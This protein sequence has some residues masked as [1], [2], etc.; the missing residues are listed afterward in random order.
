VLLYAVVKLEW[1]ARTQ[2]DSGQS[3]AGL[4]AA[5]AGLSGGEIVSKRGLRRRELETVCLLLKIC[6]GA[7]DPGRAGWARF[8]LLPGAEAGARTRTVM[9]SLSK[10]DAADAQLFR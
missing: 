3:V 6:A 10:L 8:A 5:R 1:C 9:L 2:G 7:P 4:L